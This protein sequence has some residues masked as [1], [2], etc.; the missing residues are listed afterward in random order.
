MGQALLNVGVQVVGA[1][2][3]IKNGEDMPAI[4]DHAGKDVSEVRFAFGVLVPLGEHCGRNLDI[5]AQLFR[6]MSA[7]EQTVK[8]GSFALRKRKI[9]KHVGRQN[10]SDTGHSKNAVYSKL[11]RRQVERRYQCREPV[12]TGVELDTTEG[13]LTGSNRT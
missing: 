4:F 8:E 13:R 11:L 9:R 1:D 5:T 2:E 6:G 12:K 10:G 7:E 3:G